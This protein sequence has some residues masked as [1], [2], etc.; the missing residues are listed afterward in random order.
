MTEKALKKNIQ[1]VD[2]NTEVS[3]QETE[4]IFQADQQSTEA[5]NNETGK[6]LSKEYLVNKLNFTNFQDGTILI[7]FKHKKY[8]L[9]ISFHARPKP[10][11]GNQLDCLWV[12]KDGINEKLHPYRFKS[13]S[14]I[15]GTKLISATPEVSSINDSGISFVLPETCYE[16]CSRK[17]ARYS[18]KGINVQFIQASSVFY[19]TLVNFN[20]VSFCIE[21]KTVAP[22]TFQ[23]LDNNLKVNI[24]LS[25]KRETLYAGECKIFKNTRGHKTRQYVLEPV[26]HQ[27]QRYHQKDHRSKRHK[28]TPSPDIIFKHPFTKKLVTLKATDISGSGFS[29]EEDENNAVLLPGMV[30][31][32]LE[33]NFADKSTVKCKAQVLYRQISCGDQRGIRVKCGIAVL[34][35]VLE[36]NMKLLSILHQEKEGNSYVCNRVDMDALWDFFFETGFIYPSKYEFIQKNK[37]K[38]KETY[39]K[40]YTQH[41]NIARHFIYQDK[42]RILGHMAMLRFYGNT[43]LIHHHASRKSALNKAGMIVLNQIGDFT[44][45]CHRFYSLHMDFLIC[46]YRTENKFPSRV[47][48]GAARN[49]KDPKKC[50]VDDFAYFHYKNIPGIHNRL[51]EPWQLTETSYEDLVELENFYK[52]E[53]SDGLMLSALDLEPEMADL[54]ELEKEYQ[55]LGFKRQ[56]LLFSLKKNNILKAVAMVDISDIGLNLSDFTS[57]IKIFVIDPDDLSSETLNRMLSLLSEKMNQ[58]NTPILLFPAAYVKHKQISYEKIY[59]LWVL[60]TQASDHYF[61]YIDR[62]LRFA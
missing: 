25:N 1:I 29:T 55:K 5:S 21:L 22:Q 16:I 43:W 36:D 3:S 28:I 13:F 40:L 39:E 30:I 8:D 56:R 31:P 47:F 61:K 58:E 46:Y 7:H 57:S 48:G 20:P 52:N 54:D 42:N 10:C 62:L 59:N 11:S 19:G 37:K 51:S 2:T 15:D 35:M 49:I 45:N 4:I 6:Q 26:E 41:P 12:E 24:I 50:S 18:C 34:D 33:L 44:Y 17:M 23:W 9:S 60:K 14:V 27:M 38:I 53:S 32:E